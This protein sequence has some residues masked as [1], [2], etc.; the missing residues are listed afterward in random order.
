MQ[1]AGLFAELES[2]TDPAVTPSLEL[3]KLALV[4]S[5]D[6]EDG[7]EAGKTGTESSNS[8]DA[9]LVEEPSITP[10]IELDSEIK[11]VLGE[12]EG[13]EQVEDTPTSKSV[14]TANTSKIVESQAPPPLP[15]RKKQVHSDSVMMFGMSGLVCSLL[16]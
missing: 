7:T 12:G 13:V 1:L 15:P 8:T 5:K 9:T 3:A 11:S 16:F 10:G 2:S 4:T 6:E 14:D